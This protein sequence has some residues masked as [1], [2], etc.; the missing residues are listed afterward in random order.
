MNKTILISLMGVA[1]IFDAVSIQLEAEG[2]ERNEE[3]DLIRC[4]LEDFREDLEE[5]L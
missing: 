5:R 3:F 1:H 2:G 4:A